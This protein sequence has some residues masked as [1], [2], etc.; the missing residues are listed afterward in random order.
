MG[1]LSGPSKHVLLHMSLGIATTAM[2]LQMLYELDE[3]TRSQ[4]LDDLRKKSSPTNMGDLVAMAA[5]VI[6]EEKMGWYKENQFLGLIVGHLIN[7]GMPLADATYVREQIEILAP[8]KKVLDNI[9]TGIAA[10]IMKEY[11]VNRFQNGQYFLE[12]FSAV[13][14]TAQEQKLGFIKKAK[15]LAMIRG[16]LIMLGMPQAD[17]DYVQDLMETEMR[18]T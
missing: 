6:I 8:S 14:K 5:S 18:N 15:Y 16:K 7:L 13:A 12:V 3:E 17:A 10:K 11:A 1:F 2:E 9:I 4:V